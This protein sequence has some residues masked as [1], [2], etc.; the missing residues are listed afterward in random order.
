[1]AF[2]FLIDILSGAAIS[3]MITCNAAL[4]NRTSLGVSSIVNQ[5]TGFL[6]LW[7]VMAL[8]KNSK[9]LNPPHLHAPW[10]YWFSGIFG[11]ALIVI[12]IYSVSRLGTSFAMA[13][14]VFG[15]SLCGCLFD[16]TGFLGLPRWH[17]GAAKWLTLLLAAIGI[18]VMGSGSGTFHPL[19]LLA[20]ISAGA[21]TMTQMVLNSA[22]AAR[23]GTLFS[24]RH[25]ALGGL[26]C[27]ILLFG[28]LFRQ[29]TAEGFA[30]LGSVSPILTLAGGIL[31]I[32]IVTGTNLTMFRISAVLSSLLISSS[33]ILA[34]IPIDLAL[35][36]TVNPRLVVGALI[37]VASLVFDVRFNG[38]SDTIAPDARP[39]RP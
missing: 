15:Q 31:G 35:G 4:A 9:R 1:M 8:T 16:L 34:S 39:A 17:Y 29:E 20:A 30:R 7:I 12:N 18:L 27:A 3:L 38:K 2:A 28:T 24:A 10:Y 26:L 33:Q 14:T 6:A 32:L 11:V 5:L 37:V 19:A 25:N 23:K 13:A 36:N 22:F 21:I